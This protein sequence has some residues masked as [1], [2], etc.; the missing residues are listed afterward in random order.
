MKFAHLADCHVGAWREPALRVLTEHAFGQ[1]IDRCILERVDFV[2]IAGDLF[3]T[4]LPP[5]DGVKTV[6]RSLKRLHDAGI[7][8]YFITGSHDYSPTGKTML[9]L[10]EEAGIGRNLFRGTVADGRLKLTW[11]IDEKTGVKLTGILGRANQLDQQLYSDLDRDA[12]EREPGTKIFVFHTGLAELNGGAAFDTAPASLLPKG[13]AYYA[14][15]HVHARSDEVVDGKRIVYPGPLF[16]ASFSE[17]EELGAGGFVLVENGEVRRVTVE[18]RPIVAVTVDCT[19]L[20]PLAVG[21]RILDA[22]T[23]ADGALVL[24]RATGELAGSP[25]DVPWKGVVDEL[26][27]R[28]AY[29]VLRNTAALIAPKRERIMVSTG[30][31]ADIEGAV[32]AEQKVDAALA[33]E[34]IHALTQDITDGE[35]RQQYEDRVVAEALAV[36][37]R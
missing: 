7:P 33:R 36:L 16:P 4:A 35:K 15:G 32:L 14:G 23:G 26:H 11:T 17:L 22:V 13:C 10:I 21:P 31:V 28:G 9:D 24:V 27:A 12:L 5:L 37:K 3:H 29:A 2:I 6:F 30:T 20:E 25:A 1:A 8:L 19:G 18:T 34:L